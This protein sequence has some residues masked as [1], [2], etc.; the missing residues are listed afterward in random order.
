MAQIPAIKCG[1][2]NHAIADLYCADCHEIV[3]VE[4][5]QNV[6]DK[7]PFFQD[8]KVANI[9][10]EE[11][12]VFKPH[13]VC[14]THK[15][16]F[17][18]YCSKCECLT[19]AEC[20]TS[21][22]NEHK[23][24]KIKTV[25]DTCRQ[26]VIQYME[27]IKT[28]VEIVQKN[29]ETID[30][31]HS[32]QIKSDCESY[33]SK[34]TIT[35]GELHEI[36]DRYKQIHTTT[37]SDFKDNEN[38]DLHNKRAFFKRRHD[39]IADRLLKFENL[40]Q[41]TNDSI[42]L[43]E[44]K[45]LQ[46]DV[47]ITDEEI[48]D[49]LACP[50]Q[51]ELFNQSNFTRSV[52]EEIDEKFKMRLKEKEQT[53]VRLTGNIDALKNELKE[54]QQQ[55]DNQSKETVDNAK[56]ITTEFENEIKCLEAELTT[57]AQAKYEAE[58]RLEKVMD[59][60]GREREV[61]SLKQNIILK[62]KENLETERNKRD[63]KPNLQNEGRKSQ[64]QHEKNSEEP[65]YQDVAVFNGNCLI[66][67][68][69]FD[70]R[71]GILMRYLHSTEKEADLQSEFKSKMYFIRSLASVDIRC[72]SVISDDILYEIQQTLSDFTGIYFV[73]SKDK[74]VLSLYASKYETLAEV[75]HKTEEVL[76]L[77][78]HSKGRRNRVF[79]TDTDF[80]TTTTKQTSASGQL[81]ESIVKRPT[82]FTRPLSASSVPTIEMTFKTTQGIIL[83]VNQGNILSIDVDCIVNAA[84]EK[85]CHGG[86]IACAIAAAAGNDFQKESD[87]YIQQ[88]GPIKEGSCCTTSPGKLKYKCVIHTVGPKW[89]SYND[90]AE[91]CRILRKSVEC[92]FFEAELNGMSSLATSSISAG[93]LCNNTGHF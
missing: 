38:Q 58:R 35:S 1:F 36:I 32:A 5:R 83:K 71:N 2:C 47:Q 45:A 92:C 73:R 79:I 40:L 93:N 41:E 50:R 44:W 4:C 29:L 55:I 30:T 8:H 74:Y 53:V 9:Q 3:C 39:E 51:L 60:Y 26:T 77:Q 84:N 82:D 10:K 68:G 24:E 80:K 89:H 61:N 16:Q 13:P 23:T 33:V 57:S 21:N 70:Y 31:E 64:K 37:A 72:Q 66:F 65:S 6:H 46:T 49:P 75:K 12:R 88:N 69:R 62:L 59:Q 28:K 78:Q 43:T 14:E 56:K 27:K 54:K 18:Y 42:F 63:M 85:L 90:K 17:L 11:N 19:C 34:V 15:N 91:C 67:L 76:G 48:D 25:A 87:D 86:G 7:V 52:I 81:Q 20:M 22:H